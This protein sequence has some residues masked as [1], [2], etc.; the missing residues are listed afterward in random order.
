ME[1]KTIMNHVMKAYGK[2]H[3]I[4]IFTLSMITYDMKPQE[5]TFINARGLDISGY[6]GTEE[7]WMDRNVKERNSE[8][9]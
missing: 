4:E 3:R 6:T 2:M 1:K 7:A 5:M 9:C 8:K